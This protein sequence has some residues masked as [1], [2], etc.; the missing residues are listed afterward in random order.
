MCAGGPLDIERP[1]VVLELYGV[2]WMDS[3]RPTESRGR[4]LG[5]TDV[6]DFPFT[7]GHL[8]AGVKNEAKDYLETNFTSSLRAFMV[9]SIGTSG[10]ARC[11]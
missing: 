1:R 4:D 10:L 5:E 7:A 6:L 2:N 11:M 3:M 8:D 9:F